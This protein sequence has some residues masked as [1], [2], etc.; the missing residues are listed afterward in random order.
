MPYREYENLEEE[1]ENCR[2][3]LKSS[4]TDKVVRGGESLFDTIVYEDYGDEEE[5]IKLESNSEEPIVYD[6]LSDGILKKE[7]G[8][9]ELRYKECT[10]GLENLSTSIS[11]DENERS[12]ITVSRTGDLRQA[13]VI[14]EGVR[15]F[16][17]YS[18]PYGPIE[19]CIWGR[20][21]KNEL[22]E[23]GGKIEL[24]YSVELKGMTAQRNKM[25]IRVKKI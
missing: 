17:V 2:I 13:F 16:N 20:K 12:V 25:E 10:E 8:R 21:V 22:T 4:Q 24:D 7:N 14:K 5:D 9:I 6:M 19:M 1:K 15:H 11:F 23:D 3:R 18:T